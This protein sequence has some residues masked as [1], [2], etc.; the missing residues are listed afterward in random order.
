MGGCLPMILQLP[1][2]YALYSLFRATLQLRQASFFWWIDDL[3]VPDVIAKL[4]FSIPIFSITEVSGLALFMGITMF[5]Q[6]KSTVTDPRQKAMVWM[7]PILMTL[8]F[9]SFPAGL[10]L[11]YLVFNLLS[12][13]QQ[14][15]F[16][17]KHQDEP[18]RKVEKKKGG[19]FLARLAKDLPKPKR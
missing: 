2:L 4:P 3:S 9:N 13:G 11:Y 5:I 10:N 14:A 16:N 15:W 6:Q 7:M 19:G 1:I 17:K 8:L 12:I 18:V